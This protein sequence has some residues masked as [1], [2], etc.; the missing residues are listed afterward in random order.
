[1]HMQALALQA[2]ARV[3]G[4]LISKCSSLQYD[5]TVASSVLGGWLSGA[6]RACHDSMVMQGVMMRSFLDWGA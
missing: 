2:N 1:M 4:V 3:S 6:L 5:H